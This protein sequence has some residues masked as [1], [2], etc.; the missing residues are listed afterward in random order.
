MSTGHF[1]GITDQ[2]KAAFK[3]LRDA[4]KLL[5]PELSRGQALVRWKE[6]NG[7]HS[8]GAMYLA[9]YAIECKLKAIAMEIYRCPTLA[10]LAIK[11]D[12]N[13]R[14]VYTHGVEALARRLPLWKTFQRSVVWLDFAGQ[15]NRWQPSWRYDPTDW[16]NNKALVFIEAVDRVYKWLSSNS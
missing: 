9:G 14:E 8:R 5:S 6:E 10:E 13:D 15:V 16:N 2:Q 4:W 7:R 12:V 11:W 1:N 3:R